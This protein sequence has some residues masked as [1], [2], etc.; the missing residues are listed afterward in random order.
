MD[1][2]FLFSI[3][4]P[5]I[6]YVAFHFIQW[7]KTKGICQKMSV[8]TNLT[9]GKSPPH[10]C[11]AALCIQPCIA[12]SHS[13]QLPEGS[14][15]LKSLMDKKWHPGWFETSL[16]L[17]KSSRLKDPNCGQRLT[18]ADARE[19]IKYVATTNQHQ[20]VQLLCA[21]FRCCLIP[22]QHFSYR[23]KLFNL[24]KKK[25]WSPPVFYKNIK[26]R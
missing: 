1:M 13:G 26:L 19:V 22:S 11:T 2:F 23:K 14:G 25:P 16:K 10:P 8:F 20:F 17:S 15:H 9:T 24:K 18:P 12:V 7:I 6:L 4:V 21:Q 5:Y 3:Y